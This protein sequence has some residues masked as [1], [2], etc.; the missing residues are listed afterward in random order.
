MPMPLSVRR[1][2]PLLGLA[3]AFAFPTAAQTSGPPTFGAV[4]DA[5]PTAAMLV[6]APTG[7]PSRT[8]FQV[9][10]ANLTLQQTGTIAAPLNA[11]GLYGG[12][13][14]GVPE[15]TTDL[16]K[17][18]ADGTIVETIT[19]P[20]FTFTAAN[21]YEYFL[22]GTVDG[23][24]GA[25]YLSSIIS[26]DLYVI[27]LNDPAAGARTIPATL[28]GSPYAVAPL[29]L[30]FYDGHLYGY[31]QNL[32]QGVR[33]DAATGEVALFPVAGLPN[34][35]YGS[36]WM[37]PDGKFVLSR[38]NFIYEIDINDPYGWTVLRGFDVAPL[39][40]VAEDAAS[41]SVP[42]PVSFR[43]T[44]DPGAVFITGTVGGRERRDDR[45]IYRHVADPLTG[46][47]Q[48]DSLGTIAA[49]INAMDLYADA[50]HG[51]H[52]YDG[53]LFRMLA[54][55]SIVDSVAV[56]GL[57]V[58]KQRRYIA[59]TID[60]RTGT[61]YVF[62]RGYA[63]A[64]AVDLDDVAAGATKLTFLQGGVKTR[65]DFGDFAYYEGSLYGYDY[66][67]GNGFRIDAATGEVT[68]VPLPGV[69]KLL[70]PAAWISPE[71]TLFLYKSASRIY[72]VDLVSD[73]GWTVL[74]EFSGA[75]TL[76]G[77]QD[78][79]F[80]SPRPV[81]ARR[82]GPV[83]ELSM[84]E[85]EVLAAAAAT[86]EADGGALR[87]DGHGGSDAAPATVA[88]GTPYPNPARHRATFPIGMPAAG[89]ATLVVYDVMGRQVGVA[90]DAEVGAGWQEAT[91][92]TSGLAAG[93]YVARLHTPGGVA[94][95]KLVVVD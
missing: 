40:D 61:Q 69:R 62:A 11:I 35:Y 88:L 59:G 48:Q 9:S 70:Y 37:N 17:V 87:A 43:C 29:D 5:D 73:A 23:E 12:Y 32:G 19:V 3:V 63:K 74:R 50:L 51:Y 26:S 15:Q 80:C 18:A 86:D 68:L 67:S 55:G 54:D 39:A 79:S 27:D 28:N 20:G 21:Y 89:R 1:C 6:R 33:I 83:R 72:E 92:E 22:S 44:I 84:M 58:D 7:S 2:A 14:Y 76:T 91:F 41:C 60:Q 38:Q 25:Y 10:L 13:L 64:Y 52:R 31:D 53:R 49:P 57:P 56:P 36:S 4:C 71:G 75:R 78:G 16:V 8:L 34:Q 65:L 66:L 93:T 94:T 85:L 46:V 82:G 42:P 77:Q 24:T 81:A 45:E 47:V 30:S 90:F 95:A